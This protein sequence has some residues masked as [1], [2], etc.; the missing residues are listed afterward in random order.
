M[1]VYSVARLNLTARFTLALLQIG[2][3]VALVP[4][5]LFLSAL[6]F[7]LVLPLMLWL[8]A[9]AARLLLHKERQVAARLSM[10][11]QRS[12][13]ALIVLEG[14]LIVY[15]PYALDATRVSA[16][17]GRG[18]LGAFGI[19]PIGIGLLAGIVSIAT[20]VLCRYAVGVAS[21]SHGFGFAS[22]ASGCNAWRLLSPLL[23]DLIA[24]TRHV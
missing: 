3:S 17:D 8:W 7:F 18:L 16:A 10:S 23:A 2:V 21:D 9:L 15:G 1:L 20:I 14:L 4:L 24:T 6:S 12:H 13:W 22:V 5:G 19:I 11:L